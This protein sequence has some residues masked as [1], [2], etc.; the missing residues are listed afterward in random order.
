MPGDHLPGSNAP[1]N[2]RT[3]PKCQTPAEVTR[4]E[5]TTSSWKKQSTNPK[6]RTSYSKVSILEAE[7]RLG[8]KIVEF[9]MRG[10]PVSQMLAQAKSKIQGLRNDQ[11]QKTK[12]KV[13]ENIVQYIEG[14]L[15]GFPTEFNKNFNEA[16][17]NE[18][19]LL[20]ILPILT[21][22]RYETGRDLLLLREKEMIATGSKM[23]GFREVVRRDFIKIED[24]KFVLFVEARKSTA[25]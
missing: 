16:N 22:L 18:L 1:Q 6:H 11:I 2:K 8:I 13:F 24:T 20:I 14:E 19:V 21:A 3:N 17:V 9:E 23:P 10:I 4:E 12:E 15:E 5:G 7:N 25:R